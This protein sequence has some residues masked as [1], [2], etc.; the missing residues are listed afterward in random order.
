MN[1]LK[2]KFMAKEVEISSDMTME[3]VGL[4]FIGCPRTISDSKLYRVF[5]NKK[6][7]KR[8]FPLILLEEGVQSFFHR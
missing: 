5:F 2:C 8:I 7:K 1:F 3:S 6:K 4:F